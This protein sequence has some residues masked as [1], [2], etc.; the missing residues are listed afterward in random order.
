MKR[1]LF[2]LTLIVAMTSTTAQAQILKKI[3]EAA[4][5]TAK[6]GVETLK[7]NTKEGITNAA[8]LLVGTKHGKDNGKAEA[9]N[10]DGDDAADVRQKD[11]RESQTDAT[12]NHTVF[13]DTLGNVIVE[14]VEK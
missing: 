12:V 5:N 7:Q 8:E 13:F 1:L 6:Q 11:A 3:G 9:G 14:V 2:L 10:A 4:K